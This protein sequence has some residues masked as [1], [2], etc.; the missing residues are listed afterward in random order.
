MIRLCRMRYAM[1]ITKHVR[2]EAHEI[3]T[4]EKLRLLA[5]SSSKK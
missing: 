2:I 4:L 5:T 3:T 1:A